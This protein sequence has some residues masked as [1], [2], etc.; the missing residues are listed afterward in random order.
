MDTWMVVLPS[1]RTRAHN[2]RALGMEPR[3]QL[4]DTTLPS[5]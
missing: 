1:Y 5:V 2:T 4:L 3:I